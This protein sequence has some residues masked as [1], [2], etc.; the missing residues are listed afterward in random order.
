[1][2]ND[3]IEAGD[4]VE[5]CWRFAEN[6]DVLRHGKILQMP[7]GTSDL[8]QV[9][10]DVGGVIAINPHFWALQ[11]IRKLEEVND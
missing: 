5:I 2:A 9:D 8:V 7:R 3:L 4:R 10:M 1:M 6:W 11:H